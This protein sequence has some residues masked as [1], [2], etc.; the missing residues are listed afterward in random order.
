V[1]DRPFLKV[2]QAHFADILAPIDET[3][4]EEVRRECPGG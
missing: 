3:D 2:E 1:D 4:R